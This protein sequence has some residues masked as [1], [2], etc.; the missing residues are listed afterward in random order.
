MKKGKHL[1]EFSFKAVTFRVLPLG[2]IEVNAEGA[3]VG[4]PR[5]L[6]T[7]T[8]AF[9]G[10][11]FSG[12]Y[13]AIT[14]NGENIHGALEGTSEPIQNGK[15]HTTMVIRRSSGTTFFA[16]GE[17]NPPERSWTGKVYEATE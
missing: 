2:R 16:E 6:Q 13:V 12:N 8:V 1:G 9:A 4:V 15:F 11:P 3:A 10:G 14:D 7:L 5:V 17:I